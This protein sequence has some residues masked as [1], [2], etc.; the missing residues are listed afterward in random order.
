[1]EPTKER[2]GTRGIVIAIDGPSGTGKSTIARLLA[3]RLRCRYIDT[4]AMYRAVALL[5]RRRQV[6]RED[7]GQ[8]VELLREFPIDYRED[9]GQLRVILAEE[10]VT[11]ALRMPGMGEEASLLSRFPEVRKILVEKQRELAKNGSVV[12]EGRDIGSVV[13]PQADLKIFLDADPGERVARRLLQWRES[14]VE[15]SAEELKQEIQG[16]DLRDSTREEAPLTLPR[17]G[18]R[19]DTTHKS[20]QEVEAEI[21]SLLGEEFP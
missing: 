3:L 15:A 6:D 19:V 18:V 4:G 16:R 11:D 5:A 1:M 10:D 9:A 2:R 12:M 8:L 14:G 20:I 21:L 13:L 17:G 7:P